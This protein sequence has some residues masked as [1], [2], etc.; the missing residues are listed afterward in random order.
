MTA[1]T[2]QRG[3]LYQRVTDRIVEQMEAGVRPWL[4]PW[5]SEHAASRIVRPLRSNGEPYRGV[6]VLMLWDAAECKGYGSPYWLTFNQAKEL[7]AF[8]KR[9]EKSSPVVYAG[10][11]KKAEE[12]EQGNEVEAEIPF[13]KEYCVFNAEQCEG[14]PE[15]FFPTLEPL[16]EPVQQIEAADRFFRNTEADIHEGGSRAFYAVTGDYIQVPR[17]ETFTDAESHAA[18]VAHELAH[19]TRHPSRLNREF[20]RKRWGDEGYAVEELVAEIAAA[21]LCADLAIE[22]EVREDHASYL[23]S[24]LFVL[25][26]DKRAIFSAASHASRAV[27]Y[28]HERQPV[29]TI[30]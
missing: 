28:L 6:N 29:E 1:K 19:W 17:I 26:Q 7:G 22:P 18:T 25:K 13:L 3:D 8:V 16:G 27:D 11:F 20:G 10:S 15:R 4:Q 9:G 21:F 2:N 5:N 23:A 24:W 30:N 12:D 14:L